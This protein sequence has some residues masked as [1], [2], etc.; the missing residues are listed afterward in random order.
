[1]R[2]VSELRESAVLY[3]LFLVKKRTLR[4][5]GAVKFMSGLD[6]VRLGPTNVRMSSFDWGS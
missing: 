3:A 6:W 5:G 4:S 1:M 2:K